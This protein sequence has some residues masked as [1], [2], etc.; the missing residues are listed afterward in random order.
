MVVPSSLLDRVTSNLTQIVSFVWIHQ[1]AIS[2][3]KEQF[4]LIAKV[5]EHK[6]YFCGNPR[7][8]ASFTSAMIPSAV[9]LVWIGEGTSLSDE[10][11]IR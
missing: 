6:M 10:I 9:F 5:P 1:G 7:V 8:Q 4:P 3:R 11:E 2:I